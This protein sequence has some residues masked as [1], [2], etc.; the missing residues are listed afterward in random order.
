MV[1]KE[2]NFSTNLSENCFGKN[3]QTLCL[4]FIEN[5]FREFGN[6]FLVLAWKQV[7]FQ[8]DHKN[9]GWNSS[10]YKFF[11]NM[12]EITCSE[13]CF[14]IP[15]EV[16]IGINVCKVNIELSL[17]WI[18]SDLKHPCSWIVTVCNLGNPWNSL[19]E[20]CVIIKNFDSSFHKKTSRKTWNLQFNLSSPAL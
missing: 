13:K 19:Q 20:K 10:A 4:T 16:R 5:G 14:N 7:L 3:K 8:E 17:N 15:I 6:I 11:R 9:K 12:L 2:G 1:C 18:S